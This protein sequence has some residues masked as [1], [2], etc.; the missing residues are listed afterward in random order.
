[1]KRMRISTPEAQGIPSSCLCRLLEKLEEHKIPMHSLLI[2]RHGHL[3]LEAYY[4]P[5]GKDR[6]HRMFSQTKSYTSLAV[7]LLAEDGRISLQDKI[8]GYFPEYLPGRVHPW[9]EEMTIEDMLKM[10][11]CHNMT[12]YNKTSTT[13]DWVRSFFQTVPAHRPG[14][15]FMYD[16]SASHTLCALVEKL[17]G[18]KLLDFLKERVLR[19]IGFSEESYIIPDPSG[20][21]MGG[22]GLMAK[23]RDMML[24]GL[25]L[26]NGGKHPEDYGRKG[27][28]QVYPKW[29]LDK[30]LAF[31]TPTIMSS[32]AD[33]G[34]GYQFWKMPDDGFAMLGMGSQDTLCFPKQDMVIVTTADTQGIPNGTDMIRNDLVTELFEHLGEEPLP[35]DQRAGEGQERLAGMVGKLTLPVLEEMGKLTLPM[36]Q[37]RVNGKDYYFYPNNDGFYRMSVS[38]DDKNQG[39]LEYENE[40]GIHR[41]SFGFGRQIGCRFPEYDQYCVSSAAW[42]DRYT[43]YICTW[44]VDEC[45]AAI[46]FKLVFS[47]DGTL[48]VLMRKTEETKFNEFQGILTAEEG[49]GF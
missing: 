37:E 28:R 17:T 47:E 49:K 38:F 24:V 27:G 44:L 3:V 21:S 31:Q 34:Y 6:L 9:M 7:G 48:T 16:T 22:T 26:L 33:W 11:S 4:E 35:E 29:Y 46:H 13:E 39:I 15:V 45:V 20:V 10:E 5:Y 40:R 42:C 19:G 36:T 14:Q 2:A 30:A 12:T 23:P 43:L 1:M 41:L 8:C 18:R 25:M 32:M